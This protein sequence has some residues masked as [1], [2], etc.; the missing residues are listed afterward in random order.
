MRI[1][2]LTQFYPPFIG[3]EERF[4]WSLSTEM[5][6]R[7]HE[8]A[9][10]TFCK[11]GLPEFEIDQGV[12]VYRIRSMAQRATWL[13]S[14]PARSHAP[15]LPDPEACWAIRRIVA[16]E[17]PEVVH[18]H[19]WLVHSFLPLKSWSGA[20]LVMSLHDYSFSCA[21]KK[22]L[23][24]GAPCT[25][26]AFAK[27]L[28]CAADHYGLTKGV[29][30]VLANWGMSIVQR[31]AIDMFLPVSRAAAIGNGLTGTRL[32]YTV[33]PNFLPDDRGAI[34]NNVEWYLGQLPQEEY[35]LF[36]G[37][38]AAYKGVDVLLRAYSGLTNPPPLVLIGYDTTEYPA[39]TTDFPANVILLKNWPHDAI[40]GAWR[41]SILGLIPS[42]WAETFGIVALEAMASGCPVI[43][44]CIGGLP[45]VLVDGET[46]LLIP[47]GDAAALQQAIASLLA[48]PE[49]RVRL[50]EAAKQKAAEFRASTIVPCIEQVY[51]ELL[52]QP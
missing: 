10:V 11:E 39:T 26:P 28:R 9:V 41:R 17:R 3:G 52:Q 27:C 43:A 20:K 44:S 51:G 38:F 19:N 6:V 45:D 48:S 40:M 29:P 37:A 7:G 30:T 1:L 46:G 49:L 35:L 18:A 14:D 36:V 33:I 42:L 2:M 8:V 25:G 12:R 16:R 32:P 13:F 15:P 4:V 21:T 24:R 5:A 34:G 31:Q 23:Y 47:P 22:L 50:G